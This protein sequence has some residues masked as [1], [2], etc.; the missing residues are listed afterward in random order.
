ME[1][2]NYLTNL[3]IKEFEKHQNIGDSSKRTFK[4]RITV[5][6]TSEVDIFL[7]SGNKF[8]ADNSKLGYYGIIK[9]PTQ[10]EPIVKI[11]RFQYVGFTVDFP[12]EIIVIPVESIETVIFG[13]SDKIGIRNYHKN[14][15][16]L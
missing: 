14:K 5:C 16:R 6:T 7:K 3:L 4:E 1:T 8:V 13:N 15:K 9:Y 12:Q 10:K 2:N 11:C